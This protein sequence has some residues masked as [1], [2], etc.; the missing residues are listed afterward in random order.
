MNKDMV[1]LTLSS[2]LSVPSL[3]VVIPAYNEAARLPPTLEA[4]LAYLRTERP[5][6]CEVIV[7]DDGSDRSEIPNPSLPPSRQEVPPA[8]AP[9]ATLRP[10]IWYRKAERSSL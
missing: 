7:V 3:S 5:H 8:A 2:L 1:V 10:M 9:E 4:A 6:L